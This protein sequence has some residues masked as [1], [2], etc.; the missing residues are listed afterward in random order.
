MATF[1]IVPGAFTTPAMFQ[2]FC[3]LALSHGVVA[4]TVSLP[5]VGRKPGQPAPDIGA[6][7]QAIREV[8][9]PLLDAGKEVILV[10]SSLGGVAGTQCLQFLSTPARTSHGKKGGIAK[11]VYVSA[12]V[13]EPDTSALDFFGPDPPPIMRFQVCSAATQLSSPYYT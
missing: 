1:V 7:V 10:A 6:D 2:D 3:A 8:A 11:V 9:E 13:L 4:T 12:L 5:T